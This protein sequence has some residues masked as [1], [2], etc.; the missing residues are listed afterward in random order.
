MRSDARE[1][2]SISFPSFDG[3]DGREG[4][5]ENS[6]PYSKNHLFSR[7]ASVIVRS[8]LDCACKLSVGS[9]ASQ[10]VYDAL[11]QA[12]TIPRISGKPHRSVLPSSLNGPK[13][14][15]FRLFLRHPT[16]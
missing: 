7:L 2:N 5:K 12:F 8:F 3:I 14:Y 1:K 16:R 13:A 4:K 10:L 11:F 15:T 9:F 6:V